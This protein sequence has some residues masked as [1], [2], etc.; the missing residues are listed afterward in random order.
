MTAKEITTKIWATV[1][2]IMKLEAVGTIKEELTEATNTSILELWD[3]VKPLF[4]EEFEDVKADLKDEDAQGAARTK[5]KKA[6]S[7]DD[8]L[9]AEIEKLLAK[10]EA[11]STK[12]GGLNINNQ[13]ATIGKQV[14][15]NENHGDLN[16]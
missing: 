3:K 16:F 15:I 13:G 1:F 12:T 7:Q 11:K 4:I 2:P 5:I 8:N 6:L 9:K 14:N 10:V